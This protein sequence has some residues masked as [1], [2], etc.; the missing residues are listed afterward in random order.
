[1]IHTDTSGLLKGMGH[2]LSIAVQ[3][4]SGQV[5]L[6]EKTANLHMKVSLES[7]VVTDNI[8]KKDKKEIE[9]SM[10]N[11]VFNLKKFPQA[12]FKSTE[13]K[14][15]QEDRKNFEIQIKGDL[16]LHAVT[17]KI[18]IP[19]RVDIMKDRLKA[20]GEFQIRQTD[21]KIKLYSILGGAL[22]VKD[23]LK[24]TFDLTARSAYPS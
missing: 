18:T 21:F 17:R 24:L 6:S 10:R 5:R 4:F 7:L 13:V 23:E 15:Y 19:V 11:E 9:Q 8:S 16:S 12:E 1:M 3:E 14:G 22:K 20:Q 2:K